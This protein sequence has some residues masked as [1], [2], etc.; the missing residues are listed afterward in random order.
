MAETRHSRHRVA[1]AAVLGAILLASCAP[2][3]PFGAL[4]VNGTAVRGIPQGEFYATR[5]GGSVGHGTPRPDAV[6]VTSTGSLDLVVATG[7]ETTE[8]AGTLFA[9]DMPADQPGQPVLFTFP[10]DSARHVVQNIAPGAYY[11]IVRVEWARPWDH[12][13]ESHAFRLIVREP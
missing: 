11:L 10:K 12:G 9:G 5:C 13:S 2:A 6:T 1:L 4:T 3:R 7:P 8:I